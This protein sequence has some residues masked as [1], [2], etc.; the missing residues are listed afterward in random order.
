MACGAPFRD[1]A[2]GSGAGTALCDSPAGSGFGVSSTEECLPYVQG[3]IER[4]SSKVRTRGL[5]HFQPVSKVSFSAPVLQSDVKR[6]ARRHL[7]VLRE[8]LEALDGTHSP[9]LDL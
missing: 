7:F 6:Q 2:I 8:R 4:N 5:Q 1:V 9:L 3:G